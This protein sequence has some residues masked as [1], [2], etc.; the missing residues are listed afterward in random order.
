M[1][2]L[3]FHPNIFLLMIVQTSKIFLFEQI[4]VPFDVPCPEDFLAEMAV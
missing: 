3:N 1:S 4:W 2:K